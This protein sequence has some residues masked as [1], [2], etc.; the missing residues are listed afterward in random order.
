MSTQT[1]STPWTRSTSAIWRMPSSL[2]QMERPMAAV[3]SS[4]QAKLPPSA[5]AVPCSVRRIGMPR[6]ASVRLTW[7]S[8]PRLMRRASRATMAP[9]LTAKEESRV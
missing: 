7:A 9:P 1:S 6:L 3:R 8:S 2:T 5:M 4:S